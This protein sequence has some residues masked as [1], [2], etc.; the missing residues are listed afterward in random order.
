MND[1]TLVRHVF[2]EKK[3]CGACLSFFFFSGNLFLMLLRDSF[4]EVGFGLFSFVSCCR[5]PRA[6][7][8]KKGGLGRDAPLGMSCDLGTSRSFTV[9]VVLLFVSSFLFFS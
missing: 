6:F 1:G 4:V 3:R 5:C 7:Q 9:V 8:K 2:C